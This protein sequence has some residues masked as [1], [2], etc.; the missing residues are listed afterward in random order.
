MSSP[1]QGAVT[2]VFFDLETSDA[3]PIG[4]ILNYSFIAVD[5]QWN[6][7]SECS[8]S[9]RISR[10]QLPRAGA[11][12]ANRIQVLQHRAANYP[13]EAESARRIITYLEDL[14][15]Q[16]RGQLSLVGYNSVRFDIPY[17]R[18]TLIRNGLSPYANG[19]LS[20]CDLLLLCRKLAA[21]RADFP[22]VP[23]SP[24]DKSDGPPRRSLSLATL[25]TEFGL[26]SGAQAHESRA[27]V[28]LTIQLAKLI[29]EK[30]GVDVRRFQAYDFG[31]F[32]QGQQRGAVVVGIEP[33]YE[34]NSSELGVP[35]PYALLDADH[36]SALW[37]D[38]QQFKSGNLTRAIRYTNAK[39]GMALFQHP[40]RSPTD[41][42]LSVAKAA[43]DAL[44]GTTLKSYFTTS[45]CDIEQDIYRLDFDAI[46]ALGQAIWGGDRAPLE[47]LNNR[48]ATV[49]FAR[50][51]LMNLGE[52]G[53]ALSDREQTAL[54]QQL[55]QY[56]G[57]RY[58]GKLK[59]RK[60]DR[61]EDSPD[62]DLPRF[63][64]ELSVLLSEIEATAV[65][66][67]GET[68]D[69][70]AALREF[71]QDSEI[72]RVAPHLVGGLQVAAG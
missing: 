51:R 15:R 66:N 57:Y 11:I 59:L 9:I 14:T 30:F 65:Q 2:A 17:L 23:G 67:P 46:S 49:L 68:A 1:G 19:R 43:L 71:Y 54:T 56:A 60:V 33:S 24:R 69:L 29:S 20:N 13:T 37:I 26:L 52:D 18:T 35:V 12:A 47:Q 61:P 64:P 8:G 36:R 22:R 32:H 31:D 62:G 7:V 10:L 39:S 28:L 42:D 38:L 50:W 58:G 3:Q 70:M 4:Q 5:E 45:T 55:V 63:H 16:V 48:D 6:P 53:R 44:K 41:E 27:D 72:V 40:E 25:T 21:T 34:M